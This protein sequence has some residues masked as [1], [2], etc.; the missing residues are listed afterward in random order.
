MNTKSFIKTRNTGFW[1][2]AAVSLTALI[3]AIVYGACYGPTEDFSVTACIAL[4]V[5][6]LFFGLSFTKF[7]NL[8]PYVQL[9]TNLTAF[10]FYAYS[11]Y[12]YVSVVLVGIDLDSFSP[13]FIACTV[14]FVALI[15]VSAVGV[16]FR[17]GAKNIES[18]KDCKESK[19]VNV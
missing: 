6:A 15:A 4:A 14:L 9:L 10:C 5:G 7:C 3:T 18:A 17:Q 16:F 19:G 8:V 2:T 12:Y 13:E 1:I 11:V